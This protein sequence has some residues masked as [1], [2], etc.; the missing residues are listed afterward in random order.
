MSLAKPCKNPFQ[1]T[2]KRFFHDSQK[3]KYLKRLKENLNETDLDKLDPNSL[4]DRILLCIKDAINTTFPLRKVSRKEAKKLQ[5]PW[6]TTEILNEQNTRDKLKKKWIISGHITDSPEHI[7]Y[8]TVRNRVVKMIRIA[9]KNSSLKNCEEAKGDSGKMWKVIREAT[10]TKSKPNITP[11]FIKVKTAEGNFKKI[12]N[13]TE[14]ADEMNGQFCQMG[15]NL[16]KKLPSTQALF[17]D[18]LQTPN[19]NHARFILHPATEPEVDKESQEL[20]ISKST[21][22]DKIPPK[23]VKWSA[24]VLTPIL[25]KLINMCFL[26][27]IYPDSLKLAR[28]IPIFK[29]GNKNDSSLYRPISILT[30]INR[31]FEKLLRDRLYD[32]MKDKLYR[33]QFG[34]RPKNSTEH[35]VLDLK[36][37]VFENCSKKQISCILFLDLKKAFDSVSHQILLKKLEYYGVQGVALKLFR[38]YL[39]NRKQLTVIGDCVSA[40]DLIEWGVPQGSVLGPLLFLIF[41]NDIPH[42]SDL[43]TWLFADD[44]AL[45]SS[46]SN[47]SLLQ[48][49]MNRQVDMVHDWLLA[50][51]LSVHYVDKSKYMLINKNISTSVDNDFE[52]KMGNHVI[53]RT[54]TYKYLGLL[55]DEKFSWVDHINKVCWK[56]SQVAGVMFKIRTLLSKEAMM[57]VYHALVGSKLRYGLVCWATAAQCLLDKVTVI[58]NKIITY[59]TFSKRCSRMWPLYCQLNVL[60]LDILIKIEHAKTMYKFE[61]KML[62]EVFEN[63]FQKPTHQHN[64]RFASTH[65]NFALVR[66]TSAKEKSMLK[67]I[68]PKVWADIPLHIK[69]ASSLKVFINFYRNHLIGNY[70]S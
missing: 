1:K 67:Y 22:V 66:I 60:P 32:F 50:N 2:Y 44:T 40:L 30:Q 10:N 39:T 49:K 63:Y 4:T 47:L 53:S 34:F 68:G 26:G 6:M 64:T 65:N 69:N 46:A 54:K 57:L 9:R 13:K 55:V 41:I 20:D 61:K 43:D 14:I 21:G 16:A 31:I 35:P 7:A 27:G 12:Q 52:L 18:Y 62:P 70:D 36:E 25:T 58:H 48:T 11:D 23:V 38:S 37:N 3:D 28:V 33:K 19:P 15:A 29:G 5:N 56:L 42:A 45:L 51:R 24:V 17:T 8:K 59:M